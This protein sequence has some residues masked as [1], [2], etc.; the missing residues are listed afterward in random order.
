M[1]SGTG[2]PVPRLDTRGRGTGPRRGHG[3]AREPRELGGSKAGADREVAATGNGRRQQHRSRQRGGQ[4]AP[5]RGRGQAT[6]GE[7]G[8][9]R[10]GTNSREQGSAVRGWC[11]AERGR[12]RGEHVLARRRTVPGA[13]ETVGE[14]RAMP[15]PAFEEERGGEARR[16]P[17]GR[18]SETSD[19]DGE[20]RRRSRVGDEARPRLQAGVA[21]GR[22]EARRRPGVAVLGAGGG[23]WGERRRGSN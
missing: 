4:A 7:G 9:A 15:S 21:R 23:L 22:G 20:R 16:G 18:R 6:V 19:G 2:Q 17:V 3:W 8:S 14:G 12:R 5:W 13:C 10:R 1:V 11:G